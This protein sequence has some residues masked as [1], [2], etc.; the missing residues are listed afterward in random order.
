MSAPWARDGEPDL[1]CALVLVRREAV[2]E[3]IHPSAAYHTY[4]VIQARERF[5][6]HHEVAR[7]LR[8]IDEKIAC[9]L[10]SSAKNMESCSNLDEAAAL[11]DCANML[12][13]TTSRWPRMGETSG[14]VAP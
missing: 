6:D 13:G 10:R 12:D 5:L 14:A 7:L 8:L 9:E 2:G 1:A 11:R 3:Y 4:W